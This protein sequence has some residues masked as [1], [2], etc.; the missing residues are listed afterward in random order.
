MGWFIVV[1]CV[2]S[3]AASGVWGSDV[4]TAGKGRGAST[5]QG[6]PAGPLQGALRSA[7]RRPTLKALRRRTLRTLE[8]GA[9]ATGAATAATRML[10]GAEQRQLLCLPREVQLCA[11]WC[12]DVPLL[13]SLL[14]LLS[15][16]CADS[17]STNGLQLDAPALVQGLLLVAHAA[18]VGTDPTC[19]SADE[20]ASTSNS[21]VLLLKATRAGSGFPGISLD[22]VSLLVAAC[23][24]ATSSNSS[25]SSHEVQQQQPQQHLTPLPAG[26]AELTDLTVQKHEVAQSSAHT[27]PNR[28]DCSLTAE[29][30]Q[31]QRLIQ[32]LMS[33]TQSIVQPA[34]V[35]V[36]STALELLSDF[37]TFLKKPS[38]GI[39]EIADEV[40]WVFGNVQETD[41]RE[42][43]TSAAIDAPVAAAAVHA[44]G[45]PGDSVSASGGNSIAPTSPRSGA[46][47]AGNAT[48]YTV[49]LR[50][51][52]KGT[53][54]K[55]SAAAGID[56][57]SS[58]LDLMELSRVRGER[59]LLSL[60]SSL[61]ERDEEGTEK[62]GALSAQPI[63]TFSG[64]LTNRLW[65]GADWWVA[66][67]SSNRGRGEQHRGRA[68]NNCTES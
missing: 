23:V 27:S 17:T 29:Q 57:V 37:G 18:Q 11:Y 38:A 64:F 42:L 6:E 31:Q 26:S 8:G 44:E 4:E 28:P 5:Q 12:M 52:D 47:V 46:R 48:G 68:K 22:S 34:R 43:E 40:G 30:Q 63:P 59:L 60:R 10:D 67:N 19:P 35:E 62:E 50:K 9:A 1:W 24:W 49:V 16:C 54:G 65:L 45:F 39:D 13:L 15:R 58:G 33:V 21:A 51:P 66:R 56:S 3:T 7:F 25:L 14:L 2:L 20:P 36:V 61:L 32:Q 55:P 53:D 41:D